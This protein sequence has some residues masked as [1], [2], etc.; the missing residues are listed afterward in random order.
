MSR[1][2]KLT[3]D[4][5]RTGPLCMGD[6]RDNPRWGSGVTLEC[7]GDGW[8]RWLLSAGPPAEAEELWRALVFPE[9]TVYFDALEMPLSADLFF[10]CE[11]AY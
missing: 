4:T 5:P 10:H 8:S 3:P 1:G 2:T 6:R 9:N 7:P 11:K